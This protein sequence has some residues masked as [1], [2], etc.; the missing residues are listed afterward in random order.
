MEPAFTSTA[1][2]NLI[3]AVV[4]SLAIFTGMALAGALTFLVAHAVVPSL[5]MTR[6]L[7]PSVGV[8]RIGLY[9]FALI[10]SLVSAYALGQ[11]VLL[12]IAVLSRLFPRWWI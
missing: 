8:I 11:A 4:T 12:A 9:A 6:Q 3:A 1:D 5:V 2:W 10:A 7:L